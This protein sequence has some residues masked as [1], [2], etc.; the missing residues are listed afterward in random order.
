MIPNQKPSV[1]CVS[2]RLGSGPTACVWLLFTGLRAQGPS[3][4]Q[5]S[6]GQGPLGPD[7]A[8]RRGEAAGSRALGED[9]G[10]S[11]DTAGP[12]WET[13]GNAA[14][15]RPGRA[16]AGWGGPLH[17]QDQA[18]GAARGPSSQRIWAAG[19][20]VRADRG[21]RGRVAGCGLQAKRGGL[22]SGSRGAGISRDN[23]DASE[24]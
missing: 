21:A 15:R 23:G 24:R 12:V 2:R 18:L 11:V 14:R 8:A 1:L 13:Q 5:R 10:T 19:L 7:G 22:S 17:T 3:E 9:G 6:T 20:S 16:G 4:P